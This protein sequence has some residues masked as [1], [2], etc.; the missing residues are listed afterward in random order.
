[1]GRILEKGGYFKSSII[2]SVTFSGCLTFGA[3][4]REGF[5]KRRL[6]FSFPRF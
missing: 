6:R 2:I 4:E 3:N 5:G 1:M